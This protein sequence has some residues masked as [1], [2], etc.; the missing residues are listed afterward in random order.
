MHTIDQLNQIKVLGDSQRLAI[1]RRLMDQPATLSQLGDHFGE[2]AAHIRHHVKALEQVR[3]VELS[4]TH[5]VRGFLEK[6]Y[7]ATQQAYF[8]QMAVLPEAVEKQT[9]LVIGSN[10]PVLQRFLDKYGETP[11]DAHC[12]FLSLDSL[13]GLVKLR[14]GICEMATVHLLDAHPGKYN[15]SFVRH[16]FPGDQMALV[17][18]YHRE[19]GLVVQPGNPLQIHAIEDLVRPGIRL[20]NRERGAG[21]RVWLDHELGRLA[22]SRDRIA[23]YPFEV[24]SHSEVARAIA[25]GLADV[26]IGLP[27]SAL[28]QGLEF[29]P[30]FEEPY[31]LVLPRS[32]YLDGRFARFLDLVQSK[33]FYEN[34]QT[35]AGYLRLPDSGQVTLIS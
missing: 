1:L 7:Q 2:S 31:D 19:E 27:T 4:S 13:E 8:I 29:I 32:S 15:D 28:E 22:L 14:E 34:V 18:L 5:L 23:G 9:S 21:T 30:L 16:F 3:L 25:N 17:R 35:F 10:D 6:Y 33:R 26:G 11:N 24:R 12:V 20:V